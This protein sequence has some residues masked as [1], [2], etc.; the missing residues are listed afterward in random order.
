MDVCG[1]SSGAQHLVRLITDRDDQVR[2]LHL[3]YGRR[4]G[5]LKRKTASRDCPDGPRVHLLGRS[6]AAAHSCYSDLSVVP[7]RRGKL[8]A[9]GVL[10]THKHD[11]AYSDHSSDTKRC[12]GRRNEFDVPPATVTLRRDP[13]DEIEVFKYREMVGEQVR[14]DAEDRPKL[15]RSAVRQHELVDD[16]KA[17]GVAKS[18][19]QGRP[20][21]ESLTAY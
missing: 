10:G 19:V 4:P 20:F 16:A 21:C 5:A 15:R 8:R 18:S 3:G 9:G 12:D 11:P 1:R 17:V 6:G 13:L 14:V 7:E 2:R